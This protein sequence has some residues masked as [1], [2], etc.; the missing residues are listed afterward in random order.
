MPF[1]CFSSTTTTPM[2]TA[3]LTIHPADLPLIRAAIEGDGHLAEHLAATVIPGWSEFGV[4]VLQYVEQRLADDAAETGWWSYF[5][6]VTEDNTL[7]GNGG[8]KG[9][10]QDG[11]VEIG[12]EV[13]PVYRGRGYAT[14][15]ARALIAHA[16]TFA[17]VHTVLAHTLAEENPSTG[18]LRKCGFAQVGTLTDP[19]VGAIWKWELHRPS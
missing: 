17:E 19:D 12:Y 13:H 2:K 10:P 11:S 15:F 7:L 14:E 4:E 18:V 9:L 3:R 16:W 5:P 1:A 6:V 8:Y